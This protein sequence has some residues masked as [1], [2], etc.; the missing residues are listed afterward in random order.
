MSLSWILIIKLI[1][2]SFFLSEMVNKEDSGFVI[3]YH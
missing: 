3:E 2:P 1:Y